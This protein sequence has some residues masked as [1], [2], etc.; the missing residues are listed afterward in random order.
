MEMTSLCSTILPAYMVATLSESS[1]MTARSCV[2]RSID[3]ACSFFI[4]FRICMICL[5]TITSRDLRG[6]S[7]ISSDGAVMIAVA[8]MMRWA[9][10]PLNLCGSWFMRFWASLSSTLPRYSWTSCWSLS[11]FVFWWAWSGSPVW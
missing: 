1:A 2:A 5:W 7:A 9:S 10:P 4:C 3:S 6:S 8:S 11:L